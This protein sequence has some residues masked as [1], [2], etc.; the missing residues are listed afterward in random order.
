[1]H[2]AVLLMMRTCPPPLSAGVTFQNPSL[3]LLASSLHS[4]GVSARKAVAGTVRPERHE[5]QNLSAGA[6]GNADTDQITARHAASPG[7]RGM[8]RTLEVPPATKEAW[9]TFWLAAGELRAPA[10]VGTA[11]HENNTRQYVIGRGHGNAVLMG[12]IQYAHVVRPSSISAGSRACD[13]MP[14]LWKRVVEFDDSMGNEAA[15]IGEMHRQA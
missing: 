6:M 14:I 8:L 15:C 7:R 10:E 5:A 12:S 3:G 11:D 13:S 9:S 4:S 1:M 2:P